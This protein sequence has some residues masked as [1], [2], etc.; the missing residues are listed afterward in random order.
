MTIS[1]LT[2]FFGLISGLVP[3]EVTVSGPV[4]AV[5]LTVDDGAPVRLAKPPWKTTLDFGLALLPHRVVARALDGEGHEL[6]RSEEWANFPH[7][8][9][10]AEIV[11]EAEKGGAPHA[12]RV[13]WTSVLAG[14]PKSTSLTFDGRPLRLDEAGRAELP[15]HD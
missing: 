1:F 3:V 2:L 4:A 7:P 14:E 11:L 10:K 8:P 15:P 13:V 9:A 5:E 12:A 6:A